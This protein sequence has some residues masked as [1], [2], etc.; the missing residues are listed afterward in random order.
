MHI[1]IINMA[2]GDLL[3]RK[4]VHILLTY[5][6]FGYSLE[7]SNHLFTDIDIPFLSAIHFISWVGIAS[8]SL[9]LTLLNVDKFIYFTLP[10]KY[11]M[12]MSERRAKRICFLIWVVSIG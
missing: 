10:L 3:T 9:S 4:L 1:F 6:V 12:W 11:D 5:S 8:S 2:L 7:T